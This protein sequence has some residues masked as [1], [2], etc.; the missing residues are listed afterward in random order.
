LR[1]GMPAT[2]Y[3]PLNQ[4]RPSQPPAVNVPIQGVQH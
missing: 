3:V 4:E 1:L 2:V